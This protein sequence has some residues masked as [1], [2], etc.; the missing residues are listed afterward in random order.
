MDSQLEILYSELIRRSEYLKSEYAN[1][2]YSDI[3]LELKEQ[4]LTPILIRVQQLMI[5]EVES[6]RFSKN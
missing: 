5:T 6:K 1:E 2:R 3:E 4:E